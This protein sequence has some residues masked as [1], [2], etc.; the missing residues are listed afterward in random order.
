M[1][2]KE[3]IEIAAAVVASLGGGGAIVMALSSWL[4]KVWANRILEAEKAAHQKEIESYKSELQKELEQLG[5]L[6]DKALYISK[7]QYD[8]EFRIY[9]EIWQKLHRCASAS[10]RLYPGYEDLPTDEGEREKHQEEKYHHYA[11]SYDDFSAAIEENAPFYRDNFYGL[12][13]ELRAACSEMGDIFKQEVFDKKYNLSFALVRD[14]P[15]SKEDRQRVRELRRE[16]SEKKEQLAKEIREY[17]HSL[18]LS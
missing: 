5:A 17:L 8:N 3:V 2:L 14:E 6:Q 10:V 15:M 18:R 1:Q 16:I 12:F 4:G 9:R 11:E 13:I 7:S